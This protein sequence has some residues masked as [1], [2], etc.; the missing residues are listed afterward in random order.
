ML[1]SSSWLFVY[2]LQS[3]SQFHIADSYNSHMVTTYDMIVLGTGGMGSA[4][5]HELARRGHAVLGLEQFS[6][7]HHLGSSHGHTRIIR[8]AY[9][10]HP[11]Y[12]PLLH[13][14]YERWY[15]LE[16]VSGQPLLTTCGCLTVGAM[17]SPMLHGVMTAASQHQLDVDYLDHATLA[18]T[19]PQFQLPDDWI[20]LLERG[21]GYLFVEDC[22]RANLNAAIEMG[23]VLQSDEPVLDWEATADGVT[24]TTTMGT[25]AAAKL[26]I[27]AGAW[28]GELL[29]EVGY[30]LTVMRQVSWWMKPDDPTA[31]RRDRF[32]IFLANTP[33]GDFY[34]LPMLDQRGFKLA[35]HYGADEVGGPNEVDANVN[36]EDENTIREFLARYIPSG[37]GEVQEAQSCMYTLTPDRHFILDLHPEY[38][39]VSI[40]AGFSGH[41]FKFAS[42]VGEI[43]ADFAE[44]G[45]TV[46]PVSRFKIDRLLETPPTE[47][48]I[49]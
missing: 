30:P 41:G 44:N 22:V 29:R 25:Y 24:V 15:E 27:T 17:Q 36:E 34:G 20:G 28:A 13:R 48:A 42:V 26:I 10:E 43:M 7:G 4:V 35:K 37:N 45:K 32:P 47:E 16:Q 31:F 5:V 11:D 8:K 23:A 33:E 14:A 21:A 9:Y 1:P 49:E 46:L 40:A 19:Y 6:L 3:L 39:Q 38:P 2:F 12:V 18:K